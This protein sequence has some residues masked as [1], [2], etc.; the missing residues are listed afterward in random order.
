MAAYLLDQPS[1]A[2]FVRIVTIKCPLSAIDGM[3]Q[4]NIH[5]GD[6]FDV[7]PNLAILLTAAGWVRGETRTRARRI[8]Q[9]APSVAG[10]ERRHTSDRRQ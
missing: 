9:K 4:D 2:R 3:S 5:V 10:G 8:E 7:S 6:V 1:R